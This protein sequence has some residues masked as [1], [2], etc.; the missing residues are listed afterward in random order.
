MVPIEPWGWSDI[1]GTIN[2]AAFSELHF[3]HDLMNSL[4]YCFISLRALGCWALFQ[5]DN[6][7]EHACKANVV[8]L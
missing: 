7:P 2:A 6:H 3:I 5:H 1:K 8:F 4:M